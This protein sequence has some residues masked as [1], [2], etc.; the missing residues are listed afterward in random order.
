MM[1]LAGKVAIVTGAG[2][3]IGRATA[4]LFAEHGIH[5][6]LVARTEEELQRVAAAFPAAAGRGLIVPADVSKERQVQMAVQRTLDEF[7]RV[8][9][10]V[11]NAA[12]GDWCPVEDYA[13]ERWDQLMAVNLRGVFLFSRAVIPVMRSQRAG[14]IINISSGAGRRGLKNRAAYSAS[15]FGVL[16]FTEALAQEMAEHGV[17]V[18][19][20]L[21]G[22]V[23]TTFSHHYP[24]GVKEQN[25]PEPLSPEDVAQSIWAVVATGPRTRVADLAVRPL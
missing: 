13:V 10:L 8:D 19:A 3:G 24:P 1:R 22:E 25:R 4:A 6:A 14:H 12:I 5:V 7:K 20:I 18:S 11:N 17:K 23:N 16:G 15:K 21:P 2:R 9:V